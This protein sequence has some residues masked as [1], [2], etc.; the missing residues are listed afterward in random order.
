MDH[1]LIQCREKSTQL[2]WQL[3]QN[4]WPHRN[5]P[6]PEINLG[7]VLGCGCINLKP[8]DNQTNNQRQQ[9]RIALPGPNCLLQI[10]LSESAHL[11]WVLRCKRIIQE[12]LLSESEIRSRW[13]QAINER[14][15][16]DKVSAMKIRRNN[17]FTKLVVN[18]WEQAL[19]KEGGL[20]INWMECS[21]VLVG[22]TAQRA[23]DPGRVF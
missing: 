16:I 23:R 19:E 10:I 6:W 1:I 18:T 21:E 5:I 14:L 22:R 9:K 2:I 8:N 7:I 11:I 4:L 17:G 20:P 3:A 13:L 12:K 15:T